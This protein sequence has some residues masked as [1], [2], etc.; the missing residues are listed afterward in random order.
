MPPTEA[1][2]S[3]AELSVARIRIVVVLPAPLG[4]TKP[5]ISPFGTVKVTSSSA[6]WPPYALCRFSTAIM[7]CSF[8]SSACHLRAW[9]VTQSS[10]DD[11]D[12]FRSALARVEQEGPV[13]V[14]LLPAVGGLVV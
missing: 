11:P 13:Q 12:E 6:T 8:L 1:R 14:G 2:P 3:S 10:H 9:R 7:S 5:K 4:P